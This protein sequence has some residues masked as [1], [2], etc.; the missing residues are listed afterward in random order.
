MRPLILSL[1]AGMLMVCPV[2]KLDSQEFKQKINR[3]FV[4]AKPETSILYVYN[5]TGSIKVEGYNGSSILMVVDETLTADDNKNLETGKNEFKLAFVQNADTVM[6]YISD[7]IDS[8]PHKHWHYSNDR[9]EIEYNY[10]LEFTIKVPYSMNLNISTVNEGVINVTNVNGTLHVN[11]VN[12]EISIKNAANT[13]WAHTVNGDVK[14]NY[15]GNPP[16]ESSYSTINGNIDVSYQP[17]LSADLQFKSMSGEF[18]TNFSEAIILPAIVTKKQETHDGALVY[19]LNTC[20]AVRFGRGG[21]TFKFETFNGNI[22]IKK[23]S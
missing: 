19:K 5:I 22:Y 16:E 17:D 12:G 18:F 4:L 7:P 2:Q 20:T 13:T 8:R 9:E 11:N 14:V 3:E 23:Q 6:A 10:K 15:K 21:K 1:F